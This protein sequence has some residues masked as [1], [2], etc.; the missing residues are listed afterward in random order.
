MSMSIF[1]IAQWSLLHNGLHEHCTSLDTPFSLMMNIS[2][3]SPRRVAET[4]F[5]GKNQTKFMHEKTKIN[6][7]HHQWSIV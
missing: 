6:E 3:R 2:P 4:T 1:F 7:I 5:L